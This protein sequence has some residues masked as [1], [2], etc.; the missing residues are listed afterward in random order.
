M[1]LE[2]RGSTICL[3]RLDIG[4]DICC[5]Q[6][7]EMTGR[8]LRKGGT[9]LREAGGGHCRDRA[10]YLRGGI[11]SVATLI[12]AR[13]EWLRAVKRPIAF[14]PFLAEKGGESWWLLSSL[15]PCQERRVLG[16]EC[17]VVVRK[18]PC[19]LNTFSG[20]C[21]GRSLG[22]IATPPSRPMAFLLYFSAKKA[23]GHREWLVTTTSHHK[24]R[25]HWWWC[26]YVTANYFWVSTGRGGVSS[27]T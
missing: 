5:C 22:A 2:L 23:I 9:K 3:Y 24:T 21:C 16:G 11:N 4:I 10:A 17:T 6:D 14:A 19:C 13:S 12:S 7:F 18:P 1:H 15:Q 20:I 25:S 27:L 8:P 26:H